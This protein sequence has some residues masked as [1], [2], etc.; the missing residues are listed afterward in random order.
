MIVFKK[1][2]RDK[3]YIGNSEWQYK[4]TDKFYLKC[5]GINYSAYWHDNLYKNILWTEKYLIN[6]ILIKILLDLLFLVMGFFR[7][8]RNFQFLGMI[9]I[10]ILYIALLISSFF[11]IG[12]MISERGY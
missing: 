11:Y 5:S 10:F 6:I 4:I 12:K 1:Y 8:L 3:N 7:S 2:N 9:I